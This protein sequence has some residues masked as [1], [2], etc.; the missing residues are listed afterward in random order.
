M[1][2]GRAGVTS[3]EVEVLQLAAEGLS[4]AEIGKRLS[5]S[6]AGVQVCLT[7]AFNKLGVRNR[8]AAVV[9]AANL[10]LIVLGDD[11]T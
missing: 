11:G 3:R 2:Q 6:V 1:S 10:G 9:R 7:S 4:N 8:T 5:I